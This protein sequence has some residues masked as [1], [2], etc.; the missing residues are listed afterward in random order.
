MRPPESSVIDRLVHDR[1]AVL[2]IPVAERC[3]DATFLRRASLDMIGT[4]LTADGPI[5]HE[6]PTAVFKALDNAEVAARSM[7]QSFFGVRIEC[8]QC[9]HHP[10][11]RWSQDDYAALAGFFTGLKL[12]SLPGGGEGVVSRGGVDL[13]H[14]RTGVAVPA[15]ALGAA[16]ATFS[17]PSADRRRLL[18]EWATAADNPFLA[19]AIANRLWAHSFGRGLVEP[20]DDLRA[21]NPATNEPLLDHLEARLK[22][23]RFDLRAFTRELV[24]SRT[25]QLAAVPAPGSDRRRALTGDALPATDGA[26]TGGAPAAVCR[27]R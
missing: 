23:L 18:A 1:L 10:S 12:K 24:A 13:P 27:E 2:G 7:S 8:A 17:A 5:G 11:E 26:G 25:Y 4:L 14:P 19:R 21:T 9:H 15:A 20:I 16:P 22:A 6:S 3:D